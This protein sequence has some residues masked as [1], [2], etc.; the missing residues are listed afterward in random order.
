MTD[1]TNEGDNRPRARLH[2]TLGVPSI[3]FMVVAA[4]APLTVIAGV[5]PIGFAYGNGAGFPAMFAVVGVMLLL[6]SIGF[7]AMTRHVPRPGAFFT[8]VAHGLGKPAGLGAAYAA[9]LCYTAIELGVLGYF[10]YELSGGVKEYLGVDVHWS[11][12]TAV[13]IGLV[14]WLGYRHIE[15]GARVLA[16]LLTLEITIVMV[17]SVVAIAK[18]GA[19]GLDLESFEPSTIASGAPSLAVMFAAASFIG[20]EATAIFR[21]EAKNPSRTIPR[22]TFVAV[23]V[24]GLFYTFASWAFVMAWGSGNVVDRATNDPNF[25]MST[26]GAELGSAGKFV[27]HLLVV[28]SIFAATLA[29]HSIVTRYTHALAGAG[30]LPG[31]LTGTSRRDGA[32]GAASL[33]TTVASTVLVALC[34]LTGLDPYAEMFTWF[35]GLGALVYILLL[36]TCNV[37]VLRFFVRR[38][39]DGESTWTTRIAPALALIGLAFSSWITA[40]NFPLLVGDVDAAGN[41]QFGSLAVFLLASIV[42]AVLL[43]VV[44]ALILR[45]R[46]SRAYHEIAEAQI[47]A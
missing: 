32:P 8:Y 45:N 18:G 15:L 42:A 13:A 11:V 1:I 10:G 24:V 5:V 6:F 37:A 35:V 4:A 34:L 46:R 2:G 3:V 23:I 12:F 47:A 40:K 44:Q 39:S 33:T 26:A 7:T 29:F 41:S 17:I 22:A 43:G 14:G 31:R 36:A 16:V 30:I 38:G 20:F 27:T 25:L 28:T 21:D 9:I 19:S